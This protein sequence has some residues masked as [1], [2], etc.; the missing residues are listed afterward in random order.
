MVSE[1]EL[2]NTSILKKLILGKRV[3]GKHL[4]LR[5]VIQ[6][7]PNRLHNLAKKRTKK[8]ISNGILLHKPSTGEE[9][10]SINPQKV[11]EVK[12]FILRVFPELKEKIEE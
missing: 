5:F 10:I 8:L 11:Y 4:P 1:E 6:G 12:E 7:L 9:H 2:V 3:G